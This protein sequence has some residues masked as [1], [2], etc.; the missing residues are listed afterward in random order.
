MYG[1]CIVLMVGRNPR[2]RASALVS[3][4]VVDGDWSFPRRCRHG[5]TAGIDTQTKLQPAD[6]KSSLL[7]RRKVNP[8][9]DAES[10]QE[11]SGSG[12]QQENLFKIK[13]NIRTHVI[14][15][16][17]IC[18]FIINSYYKSCK[19]CSK[20]TT[21]TGVMYRLRIPTIKVVKSVRK[22]RRLLV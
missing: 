5:K 16:V 14:M 8:M 18:S 19:I 6:A 12:N 20:F 9:S 3:R 21:V 1:A 17:A 22:L 7:G 15:C 11:R 10:T 13:F 2:K 4:M